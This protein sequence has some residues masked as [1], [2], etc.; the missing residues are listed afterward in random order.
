M[1]IT[2][3]RKQ[4]TSLPK[5]ATIGS[6][7]S[8]LSSATFNAYAPTDLAVDVLKG[9]I[10]KYTTCVQ[11]IVCFLYDNKEREVPTKEVYDAATR[12]GYRSSDVRTVISRYIPDN[13]ANIGVWWDSATKTEFAR[14]YTPT[15]LTRQV[16]S[17]L[18]G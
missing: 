2:T 15:K 11:F 9:G 8:V 16:E 17:L 14:W 6:L 7:K 18:R 3:A 13:I 1:H 5:Y 12:A 4:L 10:D